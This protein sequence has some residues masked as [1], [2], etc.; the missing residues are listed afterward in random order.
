MK[1]FILAVLVAVIFSVRSA[2]TTVCPPG[3]HPKACN[4]WNERNTSCDE[5]SCYIPIPPTCKECKCYI[6]DDDVC[7]VQCVCDGRH[8]P[9]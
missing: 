9:V 6:E 7:D 2:D 4:N 3:E 8:L 5:R 1:I